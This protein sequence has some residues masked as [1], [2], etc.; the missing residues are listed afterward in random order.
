MLMDETFG[1]DKIS[2][3]FWHGPNVSMDDLNSTKYPLINKTSRNY[4]QLKRM[5]QNMLDEMCSIQY[6]ST[7]CYFRGD[8]K[9]TIGEAVNS[10]TD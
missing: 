10:F 5:L 3:T 2:R 7:F 1:Y 9:E 6:I 8:M 4:I